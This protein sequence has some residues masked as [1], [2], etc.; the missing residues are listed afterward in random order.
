MNYVVAEF[1]GE[2]IHYFGV[3]LE[4]TTFSSSIVNCRCA[5]KL[6]LANTTLI[7]FEVTA[8]ALGLRFA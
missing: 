4:A 7:E 8:A 5:I 2:S 3:K 1:R 6:K